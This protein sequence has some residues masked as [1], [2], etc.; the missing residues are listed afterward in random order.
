MGEYAG[1]DELMKWTARRYTDAD[2][3][4]VGLV[5]IQSLTEKERARIFA[6]SSEGNGDTQV[7]RFIAATVVDDRGY[8][9]WSDDQL[10]HI[11]ALDSRVTLALW[12]A[13]ERH[14]SS[15][16]VEEIG[17]NLPEMIDDVSQ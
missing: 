10:E 2:I 12:D 16:R 8:R 11:L 7:A 1:R 14:I 3:A 17:K 13:I 6:K 5:R 4:D 15:P 9:I